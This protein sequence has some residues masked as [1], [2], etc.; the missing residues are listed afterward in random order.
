[1]K[2]IPPVLAPI[3][4]ITLAASSLNADVNVAVDFTD[5][6]QRIGSIWDLWDV[7][8]RI[9][10]S[11]GVAVRPSMSVNTVRMIGG[12]LKTEN[13]EKVPDLD[14]DTCTYDE[15]TQTYTYHFDRLIARIDA[16]IAG[17]TPIH[18]IVLDQPPWAFQTGYTFIPTGQQDGINFRENERQSI[19]GNSLPPADKQAYSDY[20]AAL[21]QSLVDKYGQETVLRWRFR[22][23]SEIETPEH[24]YGTEQDFIEFFALSEQAIRSVLPDATIGLH[25]RHPDFEYRDGTVKN[26]KGESIASFANG[27]IEYCHDNGIRYDFWGISDYPI[28]SQ[29]KTRRPHE[30]FNEMFEALVSHPKWQSG[31]ELDVEEFSVVS[32]IKDNTLV[33]SNSPHADCFMVAMS[34][35]FYEK[36]VTDVF[37][38][39]Q[40]NSSQIKWRTEALTQM[41][42]KIL[43]AD[44]I[45]GTSPGEADPIGA[46]AARRASDESIDLILYNYDSI[47][48]NGDETKTV[49]I[50]LL[51][52]LPPGSKLFYRKTLA[53]KKQHAFYNFMEGEP[54]SGWLKSGFTR[55]GSPDSVLNEAGAAAWSAYQHATPR[56]W[57]DWQS[58]TTT[59]RLDGQ[60]GSIIQISTSLPLFS[61]EKI[62]IRW[63]REE[64]GELLLGWDQWADANARISNGPIGSRTNLNGSWTPQFRAGSNDLTFGGL[65]TEQG[66]ADSTTGTTPEFNYTGFRSGGSG[67]RSIDFSITNPSSDD[68][69]LGFF[70]LDLVSR[71]GSGATWQLEILE[72]GA[73]TPGLVANGTIEASFDTNYLG[74]IDVDLKQ[75]PDALLDSGAT[76]GFRLT[77]STTDTRSIDLDNVGLSQRG[78][79]VDSFDT[80]ANGLPDHW[81]RKY[82]SS[83]GNN[84]DLDGDGDGY[85]HIQE[86]VL[87]TNP[88]DPNSSLRLEIEP[89][90]DSVHLSWYTAYDRKYTLQTTQDLAV[91]SW[92]EPSEPINGTGNR[93]QHEATSSENTFYQIKVDFE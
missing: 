11:D 70:H 35:H 14:F 67:E 20:L 66:E 3:A 7:A 1:M 56:T 57:T 6:E 10:P 87:G 81:E 72:G 77:V 39:G 83:I 53:G 21:I 36:G 93:I 63:T 4:A 84:A 41:Q 88:T 16:I 42:G 86:F 8:N 49:S 33:T 92:S 75:L 47:D 31:T 89:T 22:V 55:Y 12:I 79:I 64:A 52:P 50:T 58:S 25:T 91:A 51:T 27:L 73:L 26:Y 61:F 38:W 19:Y 34:D 80:D 23:G 32:K 46:I 2:L 37:Q 13:G 54:S 5:D 24:W 71:G 30:K 44:T 40:R 17:G 28:I 15:N 65:A 60:E 59:S 76:A 18:Q 29:E 43:Y 78:K 69:D 62:E 45:T 9:S 85:T 48:L 74:N 82:F 90:F 68:L